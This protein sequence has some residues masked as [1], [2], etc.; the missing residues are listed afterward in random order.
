MV[1]DVFSALFTLR[2]ANVKDNVTTATAEISKIIL[3]FI[4]KC[5]IVLSKF[6]LG[7][8]EP[9]PPPFISSVVGVIS[10][11][12]HA[13]TIIEEATKNASR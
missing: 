7:E 8:E 6:Y 9:A 12:V 2:E 11:S 10:S 13:E 5:V 4:S 3:V 1:A